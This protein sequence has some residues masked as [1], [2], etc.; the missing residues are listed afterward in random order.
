MKT[1][2]QALDQAGLRDKVR[3]MVGGA[4]VTS[5]YAQSIGADGYSENAAGAVALARNLL[6]GN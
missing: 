6:A 5:Q 4:P 2:I 3:I 1:T